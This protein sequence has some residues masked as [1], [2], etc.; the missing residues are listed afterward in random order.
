MG[1]S[2]IALSAVVVLSCPA[3]AQLPAPTRQPLARVVDLNVGESAEVVLCD[4]SKAA[5]KLLDLKETADDIRGAVRRAVATVQ[6]GGVAGPTTI[7][8]GNYNLPV[9]AGSI[10]IDCPITKGYTRNANGDHWALT[11]DAR[12]RLW[13]AG[14]PWMEPGTFV[15]PIKQRWFAT[16]TQMANEPVF[17]DGGERP[18]VKRIYYHYGLDIGGTEEKAEVVAATDGVVVS[19][20]RA[21]MPGY[22]DTPAK[23]R[24]DVVYI[25]DERGWFYRYSHLYE[26]DPAVVLGAKVKMGQ[27]IGLLG[28]EG[29][30]GGW[31]HLHFDITMKQPDGR[32]G[33]TDGYAYI[34]EA[35]VKQYAP[36]LIAVARPHHLIKAGQQV[37]LDGS[38]SWSASGS[39][40]KYEWTFCDGTTAT[41]PT[42]ERT[43]PKAGYFSEILRITDAAGNVEHDFATVEVHEP[44]RPLPPT[45]HPNYAPTM[46]VKAGEP[47]LFRVRTFRTQDGA[48][49]WDFGDG[50]P[51]MVVQSD[52]NKVMH[53]KDGYARTTHTFARPGTYLVKVERTDALGRTAIGRLQVK[54]E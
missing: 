7:V 32:W 15:Y 53:A 42:V 10:Q 38:R 25:V 4:G 6:I 37:V 2:L 27:R 9:K 51:P 14:S 1:P 29:G 18:E 49:Q 36:K 48:E 16:H 45:I 11:R 44:G 24:Y 47:V 12:L 34:F 19:S 35:Y 20:G 43:Y 31:S 13:P 41:G 54:V 52:G 33:I 17:A 28:K 40:A 21:L 39:I 30:S 5:V 8:S 22:N 50:A 26:I 46:N 23:P 3:L